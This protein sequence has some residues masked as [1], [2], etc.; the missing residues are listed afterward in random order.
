MITTTVLVIV[1]ALSMI[2][3]ETNNM[4]P[5]SHILYEMQKKKEALRNCLSA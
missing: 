1:K 5:N 2:K 4:I 3:K